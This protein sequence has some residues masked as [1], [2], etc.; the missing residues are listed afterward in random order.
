VLKHVLNSP[1]ATPGHDRRAHLGAGLDGF[2]RG[3]LRQ[4]GIGG[5]RQ[6]AGGRTEAKSGTS[7]RNAGDLDDH[8][9][10]SLQALTGQRCTILQVAP[11]RQMHGT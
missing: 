1:E 6:M 7:N 8:D 5:A 2:I 11:A 10:H 4:D 9:E 3:W